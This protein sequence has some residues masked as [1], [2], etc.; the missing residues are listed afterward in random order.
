MRQC[1]GRG[2]EHGAAD[3]CDRSGVPTKRVLPRVGR[4]LVHE[5]RLSEKDGRGSVF[6]FRHPL[7]PW[8]DG[9]APSAMRK[10]VR[11]P[12]MYRG[13]A[14]AVRWWPK[15]ASRGLVHVADHTFTMRP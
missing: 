12:G 15:A 4:K 7:F 5:V 13:D 9:Y 10:R 2:A 3:S 6:V 8:Q 11:S 1:S 14:D